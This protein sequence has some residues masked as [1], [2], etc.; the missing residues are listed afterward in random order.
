MKILVLLA[1]LICA[2]PVPGYAQSFPAK[3]IVVVHPFA[4]G[5]GMD[6]VINALAHR[7][8]QTFGGRIVVE[9]KPGANALIGTEYV[10]RSTPDGYTLLVTATSYLL[11]PV[12]YSK[13]P[14]NPKDLVPVTGL[15]RDP[16]AIAVSPSLPVS[17]V[18]D[19]IALAR[20][21]PGQLSYG[22]A[23]TGTALH[24]VMEMLESD[25]GIRLNH[26]P[27]KGTSQPTIDASAGRLDMLANNAGS[28]LPHAKG[29]KL[30]VIAITSAT[31]STL[32]PDVETIA[33]GAGL[34]G[35]D[36]VGSWHLHAPAGVPRAIVEKL[37][38]DTRQIL[39][40][41]EFRTKTLEPQGYEPMLLPVPQLEAYLKA[42]AARWTKIVRDKGIKLD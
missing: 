3:P 32:Y 13:L 34:P 15:I 11:H 35:F 8:S 12:L 6:F 16:F 9:F 28:L 19:L 14:Y 4:S 17:N 26:V 7:Y 27:Y 23:G 25:A 5:G 10:S 22:S 2:L 37:N 38:A 21:K 20:S 31:R 40:D 39:A 24:L 42:E 36:A 18:R 29:G 41:P 1:S 33:E 30:K